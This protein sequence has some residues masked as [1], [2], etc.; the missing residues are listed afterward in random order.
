M[1]D[2]RQS[3]QLNDRV[4]AQFGTWREAKGVTETTRCRSP[5]EAVRRGF[6]WITLRPRS[7]LAAWLVCANWLP[8]VWAINGL[9]GTF[10]FACDAPW[11]IEPQ[12]LADGTT[13]YG[14]I[15]FQIS[16]HDAMHAGL[17]NLYVGGPNQ[18]VF[19]PDVVVGLGEF[20]S[21]RI[22]EWGRAGPSPIRRG[23]SS[24]IFSKS[25]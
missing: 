25:R 19:L 1:A 13:E 21:V 17:D 15:P 5:R 2:L 20:R 7:I 8:S 12:R 22:R 18:V 9:E 6:P 16:I 14:A 24:R 3:W 4:E 23:S 11:R 10:E